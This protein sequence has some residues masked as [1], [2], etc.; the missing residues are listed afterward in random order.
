MVEV[1][2]KELKDGLSAYLRRVAR[3]EHVRITSRGEPVA[4]LIPAQP[5]KGED[6]KLLRLEAEG[7][8]TLSRLPRPDRSP[9]P[10]SA[11]RS[12]SRYILDER[13]TER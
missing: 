6:P 3:G 13:E 1:G 4:D 7:K 2:I 12:A 8:I 9:P 5:A 11:R 10:S